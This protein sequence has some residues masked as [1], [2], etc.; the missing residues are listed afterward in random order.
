M[1]PKLNN[2]VDMMADELASMFNS[3]TIE[4]Q[5]IPMESVPL[6]DAETK[7]QDDDFLWDEDKEEPIVGKDLVFKDDSVSSKYSE[8]SEGSDGKTYDTD[9]TD[10]SK[11]IKEDLTTSVHF[12]IPKGIVTRYVTDIVKEDGKDIDFEQEALDA[13]QTALEAHLVKLF[14]ISKMIA[15]HY[16][17]KDI[18]PED[19]TLAQKFV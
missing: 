10:T 5:D 16:K 1:L 17:Q 14:E 7:K 8:K 19:V 2:W 6:G 12:L 3:L 11:D 18:R 9:E 15:N 4:D 13:I